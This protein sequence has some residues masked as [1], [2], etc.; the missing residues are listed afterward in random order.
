MQQEIA[1]ARDKGQRRYDKETL[2]QL[3]MG[4]GLYV[5]INIAIKAK[6]AKLTI[7]FTKYLAI[8]NLAFGPNFVHEV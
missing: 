3:Y 6:K 5:A 7:P 4:N 2:P 8:S 1:E